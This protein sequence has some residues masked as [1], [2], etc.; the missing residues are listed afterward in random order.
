MEMIKQHYEY[1][2]VVDFEA[3]CH[4]NQGNNY[5]HEIIEFP[6]VLID[7]QRQMIVDKF[8]SYCRPTINPILSNF[9]TELTGIEQVSLCHRSFVRR[10]IEMVVFSIKL[11]M[12][13]SLLT[14]FEMLKHG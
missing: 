6:I 5:L 3:T 12:L 14:F 2:A 10:S 8:Q 9:C 13:Q 1:I 4:A 11:I 7:A